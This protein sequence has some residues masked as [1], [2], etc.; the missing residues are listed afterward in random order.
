MV[1]D[2]LGSHLGLP[3]Q[4]QAWEKGGG[5]SLDALGNLGHTAVCLFDSL[6]LLRE[7]WHHRVPEAPTP[8]NRSLTFL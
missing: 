6:H 4:E 8:V 7:C 5:Y 2:T 3:G 1:T